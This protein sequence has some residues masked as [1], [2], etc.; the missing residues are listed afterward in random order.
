MPLKRPMETLNEIKI[1]VLVYL[2]FFLFFP[3]KHD[4]DTNYQ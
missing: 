2:Y 4:F 3:W 1:Y